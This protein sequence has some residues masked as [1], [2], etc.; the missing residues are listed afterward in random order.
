M[1]KAG[2]KKT[3]WVSPARSWKRRITGHLFVKNEE[4]W[5]WFAVKSLLDFVDK[6]FIFDTGSTDRTMEILSLI[7]SPKLVIEE[8]GPADA[9]R[10]PR[11]LQEMIDRTEKESW[12]LPM[13]G[14]EIWTKEAAGELRRAVE[15][16][17]EKIWVMPIRLWYCLG[18]V[19]HFDE[20]IE[21][22]QTVF[23]RQRPFRKDGYWISR[24]FRRNLPG[25]KVTGLYGFETYVFA[26]GLYLF[27]AERENLHFLKGRIFHAT[28][29]LRSSQDNRVMQRP[30]KRRYELGRSLPEDEPL[31]AV[32]YEPRPAIVPDPLG[33]FSLAD[34]LKGAAVNPL[35]MVKTALWRQFVWP[36]IEKARRKD[37]E[38]EMGRLTGVL[39]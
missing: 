13:G 2:E 31:P 30:G 35:R 38:E 3:A 4:N 33:H 6:I 25:L 8:K 15:G 32:F 22:R 29:L 19:F 34:R 1:G 37:D 10:I 26:D 9:R 7:D 27:E 12:I 39:R 5:I 20:E 21:R 16:A 28:H 11:L 17:G 23:G 14:D 36:K 18:D 24:C